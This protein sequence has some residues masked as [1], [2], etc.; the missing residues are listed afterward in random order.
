MEEIKY[1]ENNKI[2]SLKKSLDAYGF[3]EPFNED[4]YELINHIMNDFNK[5][6]Y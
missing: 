2:I 3:N 1:D 5:L 6:V 4:S